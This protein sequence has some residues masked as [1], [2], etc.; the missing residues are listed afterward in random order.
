MNFADLPEGYTNFDSSRIVILPV[1]YDGTSTWG[2]GADRG[3]EAILEASANMEIYDIETDSEVY[4]NGIHTALPVT[5]NSSAEKMSEAVYDRVKELLSARK[6][7]VLLG[8]EHSVTIGSVKAFAEIYNNFSVLQID[9]HTDLRDEYLGSRFNH[10]CVMARVREWCPYVQVGIRSMDASEK[11]S[12][13]DGRIFYAHEIAGKPSGWMDRV[14]R[15]LS[16]NVYVTIDLDSIDPAYMPS[17]GT[18]EPGGLTY[19]EVLDLVKKVIDTKNVVGLDVVEL[20]PNPDNKA[21]DFLASKLIYQILSYK[22]RPAPGKE[23]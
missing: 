15:Q 16:G 13:L 11:E 18:P 23:M 7:P 14:T 8:G 2:K 1:P 10:A 17:T 4:T 20:A 6:F 22:F 21:P 5:E 9:A 12:V 3:P 19:R